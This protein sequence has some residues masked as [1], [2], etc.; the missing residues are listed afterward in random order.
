[1]LPRELG[2]LAVEGSAPVDKEWADANA[3]MR[4][5]EKEMAGR[6]VAAP[7]FLIEIKILQCFQHARPVFGVRIA[8][9]R[10]NHQRVIE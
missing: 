2:G 5:G 3:R 8:Q 6:V 1:M 4:P 9:R 10:I 7:G